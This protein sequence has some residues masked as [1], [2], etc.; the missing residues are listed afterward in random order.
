LLDEFRIGPQAGRNER[1]TDLFAFAILHV[2]GE[3]VGDLGREGIQEWFAEARA[4][5]VRH[6]QV[7]HP[8]CPPRLFLPPR[9]VNFRHSHFGALARSL[10]IAKS[11][12]VGDI[13]GGRLEGLS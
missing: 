8:L 11:G 2:D 7:T 6:W 9:L 5:G 10:H 3:A 12:L 1:L 4:I 13:G